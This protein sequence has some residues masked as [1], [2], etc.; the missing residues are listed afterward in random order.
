M[1]AGARGLDLGRD[2]GRALGDRDGDRGQEQL[3]HGCGVV[4]EAAVALAGVAG[5]QARA[6]TTVGSFR[7]SDRVGAVEGGHAAVAELGVG[8][9]DP[10]AGADQDR[11]P[12]EGARRGVEGADRAERLVLAAVGRRRGDVAAE[13]AALAQLGDV[14]GEGP[15]QRAAAGLDVADPDPRPRLRRR[16]GGRAR[17]GRAAAGPRPG[18]S[19]RSARSPPPPPDRPGAGARSSSASSRGRRPPPRRRG[20]GS[21]SRGRRR[22]RRIPARGPARRR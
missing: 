7:D 21:G 17:G 22:S 11:V 8:A 9:D 16:P 12:A 2:L 1:A 5:G 4:A 18:R 20:R 15:G 13:E 3:E 10:R 19:P 14:A 6:E